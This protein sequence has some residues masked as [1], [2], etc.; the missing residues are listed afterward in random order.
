MRLSFDWDAHDRKAVIE[1]MQEAFRHRAW[2][3]CFAS[4]Y[5]AGWKYDYSTCD[6]LLSSARGIKRHYTRSIKSGGV[7]GALEGRSTPGAGQGLLGSTKSRSLPSPSGVP[8]L[9]ASPRLLF[10]YPE[11][12]CDSVAITTNELLRLP[13]GMYLNDSLI[14]FDLRLSLER[15]T[16]SVRE[17]CHIFSCFFFR[18]LKD[19]IASAAES[20]T[21]V[22]IFSKSLVVIPINEHLHWYMA[23]IWNASAALAPP[24]PATSLDGTSYSSPKD[25]EDDDDSVLNVDS[26]ALT[27]A[28]APFAS[29]QGAAPR[30]SS[31]GSSNVDDTLIVIFDSLG[32]SHRTSTVGHIKKFIIKE[33]LYKHG[34]AVAPSAIRSIS[35]RLP[36]QGNHYDCGCFLLE[37][38][39]R[40]L[41]DPA[42]VVGRIR[43]GEE[44]SSWFPPEDAAM[45]RTLL[46]SK[47]ESLTPAGSHGAAEGENVAVE[48]DSKSDVELVQG[49]ARR[50]Q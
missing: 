31:K 2:A 7:Q 5:E 20:L 48:A 9:A 40:L 49:P 3:I 38:A 36:R 13:S 11:G 14:D 19:N 6:Q 39:S 26:D 34:V 24:E 32:R 27:D 35:P 23:L 15:C 28:D 50:Q 18:K 12:G 17:Q 1:G 46:R 4:I 10:M 45:R 30:P 25:D 42:E 43:H 16:A 29:S 8:A 33:A 22:D 37:Y 47:I 21:K 44:M 41:K